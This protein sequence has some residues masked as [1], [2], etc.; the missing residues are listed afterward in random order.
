M[1][2][3]G[4]NSMSITVFDFCR[5]RATLAAMAIVLLATS[6]PAP[7]QRTRSTPE[8]GT[9][10]SGEQIASLHPGHGLVWQR[11]SPS[12]QQPDGPVLYQLLFSASGTP[13][14]VPVFDTNPRHLANSPIAIASGNIVI[15]GNG[16]SI[17]GSTGIVTFAGGQ[18]FPAS[19]SL[20]GEVTGP[21]SANVVSN[22]VSTNSANAIVRRD[23]TGNFAAGTITSS[24]NLVLPFTTSSSV[25]VITLN[26]LPFL[27]AFGSANTFVGGAGN[28]MLGP[29]ASGNTAVG[30]NALHNHISGQFNDAFGDNALLSVNTFSNGNDAFGGGA[31]SGLTGG[32]S[33]IGVGRGAGATLTTGSNNIYIGAD[34]GGASESNTIRIGKNFGGNTTFIQGISGV[35][36]ASGVAVLINSAGQLGTTT[37]SRRFKQDIADVGAESDVLMKLRPVAFYYKPELD[38]THTRQYGLVAEEVAEI[39]PNLVVLDEQGKPQTVRYHFVNAMLLNEVQKQRR[40]I[41]IE[42]S[43]NQARQK[44]LATQQ[45]LIEDQGK[46]IEAL[47]REMASLQQRIAH[48]ER[49]GPKLARMLR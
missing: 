24:G 1:A 34:A 5:R 33:N 48:V 13:G 30:L 21:A 16:F 18:T 6:L 41:E 29:S 32:D 23:G 35:T 42:E 8:T 12:I 45:Q 20:A 28:F 14:T 39:A 19:G 43:A 25:G 26:G 37:S 15:G 38:E 44:Q 11:T 9:Y 31:L 49:Q 22:A 4:E 10:S 7:G 36:S 17:D 46:E 27:Q 47:R 3:Q 40:L 2:E